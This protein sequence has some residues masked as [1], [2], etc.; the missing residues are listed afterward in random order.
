M[1][2]SILL[3]ALIVGTI[4][5]PVTSNAQTISLMSYNIGSSNWF[6][7]RDSVVARIVFNDPDVFCAIEATGNKRPFI[8]TSFPDYNLLKT[9][10]STPN[11]C[12]SHIFYRK[13]MFMVIDSGYIQLDTYGGYMGPNRYVNWAIL[14]ENT[15]QNQFIIYA[16]HFLFVWPTNVDSGNAGQYRH[17]EGMVQLMNQHDSLN[18]PMITAGD[19]NADSAK[20]VMLFL[21]H[22]TPI[23]YNSNTINN[24]V[25]LDDSWYMA[26]PIS[27]KPG[28]VGSGM[29]AIDWILATPS[30]QVL[31]AIIDDQG[32]NGNGDF[33]SDHLPLVITFDFPSASSIDEPVIN[34]KSVVFPNPFQNHIRF[35]VTEGSEPISVQI[36]DVMG[37]IIKNIELSEYNAGSHEI[38]IDL[39]ELNDGLYFY[40]LQASDQLYRGTII[41]S[42]VMTR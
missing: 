9:F 11:I 16:S 4:L 38:I 15:N 18:I 7:N 12:E 2:N 40:N 28:T 5:F 3:V 27:K 29:M 31:T 30:T 41:K 17:A 34:Y 39:N 21:Q 13:N 14:E 37:R 36:I 10:A 42:N 23:T 8:E 26:N 20:A 24:P 19:F 1:R 25:E 6:G 35:E 22:Q 33:P 32:V